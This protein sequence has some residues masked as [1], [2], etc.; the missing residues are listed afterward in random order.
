MANVV[1]ESLWE[2]GTSAAIIGQDTTDRV[3]HSGALATPALEHRSVTRGPR[4]EQRE[5]RG[6]MAAT[7]PNRLPMS[8]MPFASSKES[9]PP[10]GSDAASV[11]A[12]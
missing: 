7:V 1:V 8:Q 12:R 5:D 2:H 4:S 11:L 3:L 9:D 10:R 6:L